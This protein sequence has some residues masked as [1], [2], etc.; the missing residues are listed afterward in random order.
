[1]LAVFLLAPRGLQAFDVTPVADAFVTSANPTSNYGGGGALA[2]SAAGLPKGELQTLFRF[3][4]GPAKAAFDAAY[5]V[6]GWSLSSASLQLSAAAAG[7]AVFN[8]SAAGQ[9]AVEWMQNDSWVEGSGTPSAPGASGIMWSTLPS[10]LSGSD[11][12]LGTLAFTGATSGTTVYPLS[13]S[14]GL[15][16]DA[17]AGGLASLR[18]FAA[19]GDAS[20][21]GVFNSRTFN[22]AAS[23]PKLILE[24]VQVPEPSAAALA[25]CG[26]VAL[27][28][29]TLN[30]RFEG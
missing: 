10:F 8:A 16:A 5:G 1:M 29:A 27:G 22:T 17:T 23:R 21:S 15:A 25:A 13:I 26:L 4:L 6:S 28:A 2:T 24:A 14:S 30:R 19:A 9:V 3:D 7:N 18:L 11:Q 12:L 20:V